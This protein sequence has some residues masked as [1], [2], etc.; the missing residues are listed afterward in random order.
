MVLEMMRGALEY[1]GETAPGVSGHI[2]VHKIPL[3]AQ[4]F[5]AHFRFPT[6]DSKGADQP[7]TSKLANDEQ[8]MLA[9]GYAAHGHSTPCSFVKSM[10]STSGVR[11]AAGGRSTPV[12]RHAFS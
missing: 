2:N 6:Q 4:G 11:Y 8:K 10:K 7:M 9:S 5:T 12:V 3:R 1:S